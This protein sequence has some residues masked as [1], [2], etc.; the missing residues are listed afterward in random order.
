MEESNR[1]K[2]KRVEIHTR[3]AKRIVQHGGVRRSMQVRELFSERGWLPSS[4]KVRNDNNSCLMVEEDLFSVAQGTVRRRHQKNVVAWPHNIEHLVFS[5]FATQPQ[6]ARAKKREIRFLRQANHVVTISGYDSWYLAQFGIPSHVVPYFPPREIEEDLLA[7]R[8]RRPMYS[9]ASDILLLGTCG[10]PPTADA[11]RAVVAEYRKKRRDYR[12]LV[13]GYRCELLENRWDV[14]LGVEILGGIGN[15]ELR[16][17]LETVK[18]ALVHQRHGTGQLTRIAEYL[19][20]GV[21]VIATQIA[22]R[23][24]EGIAGVEVIPDLQA[25]FK[26]IDYGTEWKN[27]SDYMTYKNGV[28]Q[29]SNYVLSAYEERF[30]GAEVV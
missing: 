11:A 28:E 25:L 9:S 30:L 8:S 15:T 20:A 17:L 22:A 13:V 19:V 4:Y 14:P 7:I 3:F 1:T 16:H 24:Y 6:A 2:M 5:Q 27:E 23:G 21:P 18:A 29:A 10:N 26:H 12:L